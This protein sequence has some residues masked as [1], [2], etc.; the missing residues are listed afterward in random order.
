[1]GA[2]ENFERKPFISFIYFVSSQPYKGLDRLRNLARPSF[3]TL[4]FPGSYM[5]R[6]EAKITV[7]HPRCA[8]SAHAGPSAHAYLP[9]RSLRPS[10][11]EVLPAKSEGGKRGSRFSMKA[12]MPSSHSGAPISMASASTRGLTV[13]RCRLSESISRSNELWFQHTGL[14]HRSLQII[15]RRPGTRLGQVRHVGYDYNVIR[16]FR[17]AV[18]AAVDAR[19]PPL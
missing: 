17:V 14:L 6:L 5:T 12:F 9:Y 3:R 8:H 7:M 1:M 2:V 11:I 10:F 19:C 4:D 15:T 16:V 13:R 18:D